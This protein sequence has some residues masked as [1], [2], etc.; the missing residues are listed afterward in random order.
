MIV[1][2]IA[3]AVVIGT[4]LAAAV[5]VTVASHYE[6]AGRSLAGRPPGP[7]SALAR[8]LVCLRVGGAVYPSRPARR[9]RPLPARRTPYPAHSTHDYPPLPDWTDPDWTDPDWTDTAWPADPEET[10]PARDR[11]LTLPRS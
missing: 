9:R 6:D 5:L 3:A 11:T 10:S 2:L 7:F 8:R 1:L 4:P